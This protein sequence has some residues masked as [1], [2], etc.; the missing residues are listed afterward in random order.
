M[1]RAVSPEVRVSKGDLTDEQAQ[2]EKLILK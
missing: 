2:I 1:E